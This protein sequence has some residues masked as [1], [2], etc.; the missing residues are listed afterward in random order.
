MAL[1]N[2]RVLFAG[3]QSKFIGSDVMKSISH[4]T[5]IDTSQPA[6]KEATIEESARQA[7]ESSSSSS[8]SEDSSSESDAATLVKSHRLDK[9]D[10][11]VG[12][13]TTP[14]P[15]DSTSI[16]KAPRKLIEDEARAVGRVKK[17]IV[18]LAL[19]CFVTSPYAHTL[20]R[21][22]QIYF[23][24]CGSYVRLYTEYTIPS[25]HI[26]IHRSTGHCFAWSS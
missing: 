21:Q 16:K 4:S 23:Q 11:E 26:P 15:G 9:T 12:S 25:T 19:L 1:D 3:P 13:S 7:D 18:S 20:K 14:V 17:E 2:G 6:A 10:N 5:D 8:S 24:A 22:W